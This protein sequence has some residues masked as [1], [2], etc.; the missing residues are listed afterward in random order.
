VG[1][2][3]QDLRV[4]V[5]NEV[6]PFCVGMTRRAVDDMVE[7]AAGTTRGIGGAPLAE[8]P[9]FQR[10]LGLAE[11]RLRAAQLLYRDAIGAAWEAARGGADPSERVTLATATAHAHVAET[12][13]EVVSGLFRYGGG[14]VLALS[15]PMQRH[16]RN[17][18]AVRQH[19]AATEE[20]YEAAGRE[21]LAR[22]VVTSTEE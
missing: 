5:G 20:H 3:P 8:R 16:L 17:A 12:C 21:R 19:V 22:R 7:V 15:H 6:P 10:E 4:F 2:C 13:A 9:V 14:R 11:V 18:M 1:P